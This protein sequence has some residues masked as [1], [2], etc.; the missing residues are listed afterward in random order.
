MSASP[1]A[2]ATPAATRDPAALPDH[3][4][5]PASSVGKILAVGITV[6][7]LTAMIVVPAAN[8]FRQAFGISWEALRHPTA[9]P[10]EIKAGVPA[11]AA[12]FYVPEQADTSGMDR[13]QRRAYLGGRAQSEKTRDAMRMTLGVVAVVVPLNLLFGLAAAWAI[14]KFRFR[15]RT[16]MLSLIDLP[17]AVSPV[18]AGLIF[19]LL[20]GRLGSIGDWA[21]HFRWPMPLSAYWAGF[22][23]S[24][25]PVGFAQWQ[26]GIIFTPL[27]IV[28]A[29]IFVTFPFVARALIPLMDAQGADQEQAA[30][31]LGANG[32]QMFWRVTLP[33]IKWALLYGIVLCTARAI[34]EFG[35]V[36]VVSGNVDANDTMPLRIEKL[37]QEYKTQSAFAVASVLTGISIVTLLLKIV[38]ERRAAGATAE[39]KEHP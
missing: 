6:I 22:G 26:E 7:F 21:T 28:L 10:A 25:W 27:A 14:S 9:L 3:L 2:T 35:A 18:V 5:H 24:W 13:A 37:W 30:L 8:V 36:S 32:R 11:Y 23:A 29:T 4:R 15:G 12:T 33:Q 16:L 19:I 1:A 34:G 38:I 31:T 17:F 20:L 39:E